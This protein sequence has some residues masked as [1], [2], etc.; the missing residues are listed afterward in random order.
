[1]P[2]KK[3]LFY[4]KS[5]IDFINDRLPSDDYEE[6]MLLNQSGL[7]KDWNFPINVPFKNG[8]IIADYDENKSN[9]YFEKKRRKMKLKYTTEEVKK[10]IT[11]DKESLKDVKKLESHLESDIRKAEEKVM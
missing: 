8:K 1:M 5:Y 11:E 9:G 10:G 7:R 6:W 2:K 3:K 4:L